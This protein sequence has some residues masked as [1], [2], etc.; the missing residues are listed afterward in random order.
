MG[1]QSE[2]MDHGS[3]SSDATYTVVR[4]KKGLFGSSNIGF[5]AANRIYGTD[6]QGSAGMDATLFFSETLG[7]TAQFV[8]AHGPLHDGATAWFLRPAFDNAT[9]HFHVRYSH[10][11]EGLLENMNVVGFIRDDNRREFDT[12]LSHTLWMQEGAVEEVDARVNYNHYWSQAGVLRS[13]ELDAKCDVT[14]TNKWEIE[15]SHND[16]FKRYEKDFRNRETKVELGYDSRAGR[17]AKISFGL[18][19]NYESDLRRFGTHTT[20]KVTDAWNASYSLT[21]LWLDPDPETE[22]TWIHVLRSSYYIN[23]DFYL[24]LF[25]QINSV[26]DKHNVQAVLAWRF[27]PPFGSLQI[28]YQRGTS[29][30]GTSSDQGNSLFTKLSWVF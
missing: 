16:E 23:K 11:D 5:L 21:R 24:K 17:S 20:L 4:A 25:Y 22:G 14:F 27:L 29:R 10:W 7:A 9:S 2:L 15:L 19:R 13:W 30:F 26:I 18:G 1:A 3:D 8:R 28:A 6:N 12:N